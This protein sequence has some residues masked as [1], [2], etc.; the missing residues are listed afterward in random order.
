M[1]LLVASLF[2]HVNTAHAQPSRFAIDLGEVGKL[3]DTLYRDRITGQVDLDSVVTFDY[4][5]VPFGTVVH[6][7][8]HFL[9]SEF[10]TTRE[11]VDYTSIPGYRTV[12]TVPRTAFFE[13]VEL[14][15]GDF[16]L[17]APRD[18]SIEGLAFD[19]RPMDEV[20]TEIMVASRRDA[21][22][23]V[24]H[25][26]V[27][28]LSLTGQADDTGGIKF[29]IPLPMPKQLESIFGPGEKTSITLRGR[30]SI[31]IAGETSVSDPFIGAEGRQSQS[32]FP[33]LDMQQQLDVSLTGTIGDKVSIQV[34]HSSEAVGDDANRVRLAYT[35]YED[36]VIQLIELGNTNLSL[37]GS[38]LVSVSTNAQGLFG[39]KMLAKM[40]STDLTAI[41][42][43]QEGETSSAQFTPAG[44]ALGQREVREIRDLDYVRNKYFYF[45][46]PNQQTLDN[47]DLLPNE[48]TVEVYKGVA[49]STTDAVAVD[50]WAIM[51]TTLTGAMIDAAVPI[52]D[53]NGNPP[54]GELSKFKKL[55]LNVDYVFIIDATTNNIVGI[56]LFEPLTTTF[57]ALGVFYETVGDAGRPSLVIGGAYE[58]L[59]DNTPDG[60][61]IV[62]RM[63][64]ARDPAPAGPFAPVWELEVRNIYNLGLSN[65]DGNSLTVEIVDNLRERP[66]ADR[67]DS[68]NVTYI[69]I[70][71]LDRTD[72]SGTGP[73]DDIVDLTSGVVNLTTGTIQFPSDRPFYP[74]PAQVA[75]WTAGNFA[76]V[77]E[78]AAQWNTSRRI[79][80]DKLDS[81]IEQN[82]VHQY[83]IRV[84]AVSTSSTF[85][86]NALNIVENSEVI[87]LDGQRL[88]KG[89]DYDIDYETGEVTL[90]DSAASRVT[91]S[92]KITIDY[93]F[94]PLGGVGSSTLAGLSTASRF[95]ENMR[96]NT[97]FLYE[98]RATSGDR[99][100]LGEEPT[101]AFVAGVTAS[102]QHQSRILTDIANWLPYV[103]SDQPSTF[104]IEGEVAGS[105]PNPNTK[106]EAYIEDFEGVEDTDRIGL[107]RRTWYQASLP[108]GP[109][110]AEKPD[111]SRVPF[112]WYNIEPEF[113]LH[114]RD[115]NPTLDDQENTLLQ[116]LD[117]EL[118]SDP[119]VGDTESFAGVM[120]GFQG[121]GLDISQGQFIEIWVNDFK[122]DPMTR[123][124]KLRID[125][126][127]INEDFYRPGEG[128]LNDEDS[129]RDGF[130]VTYDDTGLD[131]V[132]NDDNEPAAPGGTAED[133]A[134]DDIDISR[135]NGRYSKVNGTENNL[136]YDTEDLDRDGA[137][138]TINAY[139]SY[140]IDLADSAEIDIRA[141][142]P[143]Y[144]GFSDLG[145]GNDS[146]RLYRVALNNFVERTNSSLQPRLDEIRHVRIWVDDLASVY[147][148]ETGAG[149]LRL[150]IAE[151]GIEGNRWEIDGVREV[152]ETEAVLDTTQ[153]DARFAIGVISTK[154]DPGV[155]KPPIR[156]NQQNEVSDKESSLA[157]RYV[158]LG[159]GEQIR[160]LK[161]FLGQGLNTTLY[162]DVNFW[163]HTNEL[164]DG[165]EYYFRFAANETNYYEIA[166]PL[167][168]SHF[169]ETGWTLVAINLADLTNLKFEGMASVIDGT[170]TDIVDP[171]R[172]YNTQMRGTP[173]LTGVRFIYAGVRNRNNAIP[174]SG[175]VWLN[176]IYLGDVMRDFDHAE[177]VTANL[178]VAGGAISIGGN[179]ART[180]ADYRGLRQSRGS[181]DDRTDFGVNAKTDL[182]YF[183]PLAGFSLPIA[184]NYNQLKLL[185][186]FPPFSDTEITDPAVSDSLKSVGKTRGFSVSLARRSPSTNPIMRY[187]LDRIR[188]SYS[189][190]DTRAISPSSRDTTTTMTGSVSYEMTWSGSGKTLPLFGKNRFRWWLNQI[191]LKSSADR[192]TGRRWTLVNGVFDRGP[193]QYQAN[194]VNSGTV[195]YNP[196]RSL[197][198]SFSMTIR[199][200]LGLDHLWKGINV[201]TEIGRSNNMRVYFELPPNWRISRFF[202]KPSVEVQS[203]YFED[204]GPLVQGPEGTLKVAASRNDTGRI[205]FDIGRHFG[206]VFGWFG[207]DPSASQDNGQR[208]GSAAPPDSANP[209]SAPLD[210]TRVSRG[211]PD[212]I[213]GFGRILTNITP[214]KVNLRRRQSSSFERIP[215]RPDWSYQLGL[216]KNTGVTVNGMP[217]GPPDQR[218][219]EFSYNVDSGAR[220]RED[221]DVQVR[222]TQSITDGAFRTSESRTT[223][224]Q[225]PD[226][227]ARW[228][229]LEKL[230]VFDQSIAQ[231]ELRVDWKESHSENGLKGQAP[232]SNRSSFS[233]SPALV[234]TWKNQLNSSLS[235]SY[236]SEEQNER[237]A[238]TTTTGTTVG[239]ELKK[240]FRSG[241]GLKL[242][243]K[244]FD[245]KNEMDAQLI[246]AYAV[247]GG[248]TF[249]AGLGI[250][251]PIPRSTSISVDPAVTY[252]FT[253]TIN[254]TAFAGYARRF[255]ERSGV[256]T[257]SVKLGVTAVI[258]F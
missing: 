194:M 56:E 59:R 196:F 30:E 197:E 133:P 27:S 229:G 112:Y 72:R 226:I 119:T 212:P 65:I 36:E 195:R 96:V 221:V 159:A 6:K 134:G 45:L 243:G 256:T 222:Y 37:P 21:W 166:V 233:L 38:Q 78:Y 54:N 145:H 202:E 156:P 218:S 150:Q 16:T 111:S 28:A 23:E 88:A 103:D 183:L 93:D 187:T 146:W 12:V 155:Y 52:L 41:A 43:K 131:G 39:V 217:I 71:G 99:A 241:G 3:Y 8:P 185:P 199:R 247:T 230:R 227:Q 170:T 49:P 147:R 219:W 144:D 178:S 117:L 51:D 33:S 249:Q 105:F 122:P 20:A 176:D 14:Q 67:P 115:L 143:T 208:Q 19:I 215:A 254:G 31:T 231:G 186:K 165:L 34:D 110:N 160:V 137:L 47:I 237:G 50:R 79:Y 94:K 161:R 216:D 204:G 100:R 83:T 184:V 118:A 239:V 84:T 189:Y 138:G 242:F 223:V 107:A 63:L 26:N 25:G 234:M 207:W 235:V 64:R 18:Y 190:S 206:T 173:N 171:S 13:T 92:S 4:Q 214:I 10:G 244:G 246:M 158:E 201:G 191:D 15:S 228:A 127:I 81:E 224:T 181:G 58:N 113:G 32:L 154:T 157:V 98:S 126:G 106:S 75:L 141:Q 102:Y 213:K 66:N 200:D 44:G 97:T 225:W 121:G 152:S 46:P 245:W 252:S 250:A 205:G 188:P 128:K 210:T 2:A 180:G 258:Q 123:G 168:A 86:L 220:L 68:T 135:I 5:H 153:T 255:D 60:S 177:R 136:L 198:S 148:T 77:G 257:T 76:F 163:V 151:F 82:K 211:R 209:T 139:F 70:F 140:E 238:S 69:R 95:G 55:T 116:C 169:N 172:V 182:Q 85:R 124:G 48:A 164:I 142:Y 62:L 89:T 129:A 120:L 40:G 22:R 35:G 175:E 61:G 114:R 232:I 9:G 193:Y 87:S 149:R 251:E 74:S 7:V 108:L 167:S 162:R 29:D 253:R 53:A 11:V 203:N 130:A 174:Q 73:P 1:F 91:P 179:W 57:N 125:L 42:S 236:R 24:V 101:R 248:E 104:Q 17:V 109:L 192:T 90:K 240:T 80:T 132:F